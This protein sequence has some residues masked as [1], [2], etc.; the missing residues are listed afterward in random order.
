MARSMVHRMLL[1][2]TQTDGPMLMPNEVKNFSDRHFVP[3]ETPRW[4]ATLKDHTKSRQFTSE[5]FKIF[6]NDVAGRG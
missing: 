3:Q 5:I 6:R 1:V 2:M 4:A